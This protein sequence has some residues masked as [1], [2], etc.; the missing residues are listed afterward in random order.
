M[1]RGSKSL[2]VSALVIGVASPAMASDIVWARDGDIDSLDPH[3]ATSTLSRQ[4]W[5]S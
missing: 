2:L 5:C 3:R 1:I 4:V